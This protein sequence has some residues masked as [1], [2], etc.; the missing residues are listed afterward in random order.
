[1]LKIQILILSFMFFVIGCTQS[2]ETKSP[3]P[4]IASQG[5]TI[6]VVFPHTVSFYKQHGQAYLEDKTQCQKCHNAD[7]AAANPK[8]NCQSCHEVFPHANNWK[9]KT[10]HAAQYLKNPQAC[11]TCHG[12]DGNGGTSRVSCKSCHN[13]PHMKKWAVP[14]NHGVAYTQA[15]DKNECLVC[16]DPAGPKEAAP[17]KCQ[18]CHEA[19][20][21]LGDNWFGDATQPG[22]H[23]AFAKKYSG[24]CTDCH[25][26]YTD[27]MPSFGESGGC[28]MCH[29][30]KKIEIHWIDDPPKPAGVGPLKSY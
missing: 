14:S 19:F 21:H 22:H 27:N 6:A 20:P 16:H 29:T 28:K 23:S 24:H 18:G 13:Y 11:A 15:Q 9:E 5:K 8:T 4:I 12:V 2:T 17:P 26:N 3:A 25:R 10:E 7:G 1:M 30:D